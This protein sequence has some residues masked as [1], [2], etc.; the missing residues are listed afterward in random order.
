MTNVICHRKSYT[1]LVVLYIWAG[2][3]IR[4]FMCALTICCLILGYAVV[5]VRIQKHMVSHN[6]LN[7]SHGQAGR[8]LAS[9]SL[10]EMPIV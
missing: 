6:S 10:R 2:A 1:S 7:G 9:D 8:Q 3:V 5:S 4:C